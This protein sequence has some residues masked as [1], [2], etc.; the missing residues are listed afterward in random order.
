MLKQSSSHVGMGNE[1]IGNQAE[2]YESMSG[3]HRDLSLTAFERY[4]VVDARPHYPMTFGVNFHIEGSLNRERLES[5][6]KSVTA[7]HPLLSAR[8]TSARWQLGCDPPQLQWSDLPSAAPSVNVSIDPSCEPPVRVIVTQCDETTTLQI[9]IHHSVSDGLG[10]IGFVFELMAAYRG[11]ARK[12]T[13][14]NPVALLERR[15]DYHFDPPEVISRWQARRFLLRELGRFLFKR[16]AVLGKRR[17]V[18]DQGKPSD[19]VTTQVSPGTVA[20]TK[21]LANDLE[22]TL[23]SML[24]AIAFHTLAQ[25]V[26]RPRP[27]RVIRMTVPI[28]MRQRQDIRLS[29]ANKIGYAFIDRTVAQCEDPLTLACGLDDDVKT[30]LRWSL[31]GMFNQAVGAIDRV[32][33]GLFLATRLSGSVS[34]GVF[35]NLSDLGRR[36]SNPQE[37]TDLPAD[38]PS[39]QRVRVDSVTGAPPVRPGTAASLAVIQV[40]GKADRFVGPRSVTVVR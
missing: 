17:P 33:G 15:A 26:Q 36:F 29:A 27:T 13:V 2:K 37:D 28:S 3:R 14:S 4:M 30:I 39:H 18:R 38:L 11:A 16:P 32:P 23:N 40:Q 1:G 9:L 10:I 6:F 24:L 21:K 20:S 22:V 12:R 25:H 5:A 7:L 35:S 31:A 34:T 8:L 19:L